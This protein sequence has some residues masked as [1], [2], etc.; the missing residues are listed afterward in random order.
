LFLGFQVLIVCRE[1]LKRERG[2]EG[3]MM[4]KKGTMTEKREKEKKDKG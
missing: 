2:G 4:T 3:L 1:E